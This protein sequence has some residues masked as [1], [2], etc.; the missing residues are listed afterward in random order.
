[1]DCNNN[2]VIKRV[3]NLK[4]ICEVEPCK[5]YMLPD[6]TLWILDHE[7]RQLIPYNSASSIFKDGELPEIKSADSSLIYRTKENRIYVVNY[8]KDGY[9]E[10][11]K[12]GE[13]GDA[14]PQGPQGLKGDKG[15]KGP[16]GPKGETGPQG[17]KG[18]DG[19]PG[20][21]GEQGPVGPQGPKG[22]KGDTGPQGPK[23]EKGNDGV[24]GAKGEQGP[25]GDT[26][27]ISNLVTKTQYTN[28]L[29]KKIDKTAFNAVGQ[30]ISYNGITIH[31]QRSN[32]I[33]TC[34][35][36]G[37]FKKGKANGWHGVDTYIQA[38]YRPQNMI[39]KIPLTLNI[40]NTIQTNKYAAIQIETSGR[41][42]IRVYGLQNDDVE[43]GGSATWIR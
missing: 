32:T 40:G 5:V 39:I 34:N 30:H 1:M 9:I 23:G 22:D 3:N 7:E 18:N 17:E 26:P 15:D 29:N 36:E 4:D 28:D 38:S 37:I 43:F 13:K 41:I 42:M 2:C 33:I 11:S 16:Q 8:N 20:A 6:N 10:L 19:V 31:I 21:K 12:K 35:V 14:G 24:P 27:D 25:K